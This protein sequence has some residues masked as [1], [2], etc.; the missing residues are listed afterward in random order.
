MREQV[1][2]MEKLSRD[3]NTYATASQG[4]RQEAILKITF[5]KIKKTNQQTTFPELKTVFKISG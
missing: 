2:D 5:L 4:E 3:H 1:R